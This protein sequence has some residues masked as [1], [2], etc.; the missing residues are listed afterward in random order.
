MTGVHALKKPSRILETLGMVEDNKNYQQI[1]LTDNKNI[2]S[3]A[4]LG[5]KRTPENGSRVKAALA[6]TGACGPNAYH[7]H[8]RNGQNDKGTCQG[9]HFCK[10]LLRPRGPFGYT[11]TLFQKRILAFLS[12]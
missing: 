10:V 7:D 9:Y 1:C 6:L 12:M 11:L 3:F 4:P 2:T 5:S 8:G